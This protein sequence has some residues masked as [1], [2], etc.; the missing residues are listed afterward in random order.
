[1]SNTNPR[2]NTD[3]HLSNAKK[4]LSGIFPAMP[5]P[6]E[7]IGKINELEL[8][9]YASWLIENEVHGLFPLGSVGEFIHMSDEQKIRVME[10]LVDE[11]CGRVPV[12]PGTAG[13]CASNSIKLTKAARDVGCAAAVIA[14]PY[15]FQASGALIE[16]HYTRI[17]NAVPDFPIILYNI[18]LFASPIGYDV[19][20][21]LCRIDN[22]VGMKDS[23]G[24]MVDLLHFMDEVSLAGESLNVMTGREEMFLAALMMGATGTM[25]GAVAI[26]PEKMS[27]IYRLWNT[28]EYTE[29]RKIQ[30]SL[31]L[32]IRTMMQS[33]PFPLGFKI[34]LE[35]RGF[36]MGPAQQPLPGFLMEKVT[37]A[38]SRIAEALRDVL[39]N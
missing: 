13:S 26:V 29:A 37:D 28:G 8:R 7:G 27:A 22:I 18:P 3:D 30:C 16:E 2:T 9:R 39:G 33:L 12:L 23:S 10:V 20:G 21:R 25:S 5:T 6:F 19:L 11:A 32:L 24:S 4:M 34:A 17:A 35:E 38:R 15:Y 1:M 31:L 36:R 14:P